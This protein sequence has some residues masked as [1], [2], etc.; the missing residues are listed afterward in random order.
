[1]TD[2]KG[3]ATEALAVQQAG[4]MMPSWV[5]KGTEGTEDIK[6]KD[7]Q[8]PRLSLAQKTSKQIEEDDPLYIEG[9][10]FRDI[11]NDLTEQNYSR[12]PIQIAV[13]RAIKPRGVEFKPFDEGGG[14]VDLD[15]PLDDERMKFGPNG[16][17][18][19]AT[20]FYDF[21]VLVLEEDGVPKLENLVVLSFRNTGI[22]TAKLL[23]SLIKM[24]NAPIY[25]GRYAV[26]SDQDSNAKGTYAVWKVKN[27]GWVTEQEY[28]ITKQLHETF[29]D[30]NVTFNREEQAADGGGG[31]G[32]PSGGGGDGSQAAPDDDDI[33]F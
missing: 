14:V 22:R 11:F 6:Q 32:A 29:K 3:E 16:E 23:N 2:E 24:R 18:P 21:L 7:I 26:S 13:I 27:M 19:V 17:A 9:L 8:L 1:M 4:A 28:A 5:E 25:A 10:K 20:L 33:P 30:Q 31:G 12:G 15:V